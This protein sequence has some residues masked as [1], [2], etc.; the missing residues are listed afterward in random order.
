MHKSLQ[1]QIY[2]WIVIAIVQASLVLVGMALYKNLLELA[3]I[4]SLCLLFGLYI[5]FVELTHMNAKLEE[6]LI[7]EPSR[8]SKRRYFRKPKLK[9]IKK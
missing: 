7:N 6:E 5:L 2:E 8:K 9:L 1:N 3:V 4:G